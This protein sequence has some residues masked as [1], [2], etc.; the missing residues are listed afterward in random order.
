MSAADLSYLGVGEKA[1]LYTEGT[2][3]EPSASAQMATAEGPYTV[4][5]TA[6]PNNTRVV[7]TRVFR[8]EGPS[9]DGLN[10]QAATGTVTYTNMGRP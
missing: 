8:T 1:P 2:I 3:G 6:P 7:A 5:W 4:T 10:W 9:G